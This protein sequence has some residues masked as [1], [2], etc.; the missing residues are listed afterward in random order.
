MKKLTR[1]QQL[2]ALEKARENIR[3]RIEIRE[4]RKKM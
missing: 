2:K 3:K 4:K 1:E